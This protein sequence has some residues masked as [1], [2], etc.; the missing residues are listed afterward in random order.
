MPFF[1]FRENFLENLFKILIND[2]EIELNFTNIDPKFS[3]K[4]SKFFP[5]IPK[6]LLKNLSHLVG[7][8]GLMGR[9]PACQTSKPHLN[10]RWDA[11]VHPVCETLNVMRVA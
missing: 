1:K 11:T 10:H 6:I 7:S 5:N 8:L 3:L 9:E 4:F 2:L